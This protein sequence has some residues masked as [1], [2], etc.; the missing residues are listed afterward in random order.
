MDWY[1]QDNYGEVGP[2]SVAELKRAASRGEINENS[3]VRKGKNGK[4]VPAC[5]VKGLHFHEVEASTDSLTRNY[6]MV[7]ERNTWI[8]NSSLER[9][10]KIPPKIKLKT[11][12]WALRKIV[13]V[14]K[15]QAWLILIF[16]VVGALGLVAT[17]LLDSGLSV[18]EKRDLAFAALGCLL[19]SPWYFLLTWAIAES[20]EIFLDLEENSRETNALLRQILCGE[21][22]ED[23]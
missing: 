10:V 23:D 8:G 21:A 2:V 17:I 1:Y 14:Y 4:W 11:K 19:G 9:P 16:G 3:L 13:S 15:M 18:G 5:K 6:A 12:Y 22:G 7:E 20:I